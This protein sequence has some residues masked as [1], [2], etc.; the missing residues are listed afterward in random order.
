LIEHVEGSSCKN[1]QRPNTPFYTKINKQKLSLFYS[2]YEAALEHADGFD[3]LL[4]TKV[5]VTKG[6]KFAE[7]LKINKT[8]DLMMLRTAIG[9]TSVLKSNR[10]QTMA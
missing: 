10:L 4:L 5:I 3:D 9:I 7:N 6:K 2:S 8:I 1:D